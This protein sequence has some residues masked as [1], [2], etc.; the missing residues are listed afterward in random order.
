MSY[1]QASSIF[2]EQGCCQA[3]QEEPGPHPKQARLSLSC[4][5][6]RLWGDN[7]CTWPPVYGHWLLLVPCGLWLSGVSC[8]AG[9]RAACSGPWYEDAPACHRPARTPCHPACGP[10]CVTSVPRFPSVIPPPGQGCCED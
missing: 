1:Q 7:G 2:L 6:D 5:W 10:G 8:G 4:C 3:A 9:P